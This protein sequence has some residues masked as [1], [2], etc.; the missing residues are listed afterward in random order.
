LKQFGGLKPLPINDSPLN[1]AEG[2][3]AVGTPIDEG[4]KTI[5]TK[6]IVSGIRTQEKTGLELIQSD[7]NIQGGNSGLSSVPA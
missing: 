1:Q 6:G 5:I 2:V 4:L 3:C 7:V